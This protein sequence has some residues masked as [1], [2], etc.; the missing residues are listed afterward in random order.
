MKWKSD[1]F[2]S[3]T[4]NA[5]RRWSVAVPFM[6]R[7]VAVNAELTSVS[8]TSHKGAKIGSD[9]MA[10]I[11]EIIPTRGIGEKTCR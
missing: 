5:L 6:E 1:F 4:A 3:R 8:G 9:L 11:G 10:D 7:N 2:T